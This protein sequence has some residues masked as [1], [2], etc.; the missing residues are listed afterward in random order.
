MD[1]ITLE[2][3]SMVEFICGAT[4]IAIVVLSLLSVYW[5]A[6]F[7]LMTKWAYYSS[8]KLLTLVCNLLFAILFAYMSYRFFIFGIIE[9]SPFGVMF[10]RPLI[11]LQAG[12]SAATGRARVVIARH[13]GEKWELHLKKKAQKAYDKIMKEE[14]DEGGEN[15]RLKD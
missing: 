4:M 5:H 2:L 10:I 9:T 8:L 3:S 13:G 11:L 1:I 7:L 14:H 15:W 6:Q 12:I